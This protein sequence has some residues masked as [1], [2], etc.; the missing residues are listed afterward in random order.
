MRDELREILIANVHTVKGEVW[1]PSA[2]GPDLPKPHLVLREGNQNAGEAYASFATVYEVW[3]YVKRTTFQHV[4]ELSKEVISALNKKRFDVKGV[5]HYIEYI[6]TASEDIV[7]E[8]WD[9]LT[10][11]LRFQVYS[12]AWLV[13]STVKP[14]PVAAMQNWSAIKFTELQTDPA[15]WSPTDEKP[16]AYWRQVKINSTQPMNWGAWISAQLNCH[17]ISPDVSIRRVY[18]EKIVR[19]LA[20]DL[21]TYMSDNSLMRF[22]AVSAD[23]GLNPFLDGQVQLTVQF[24]ILKDK[25]PK[26]LLKN[27]YF[28][29]ERGGK[30]N[31]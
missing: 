8:E 12:L 19:Q 7:D 20:L 1:E 9:A 27:A 23:S 5:P 14:D 16:A 2:A 28:D 25:V 21:R 29:E 15:V 10:R 26:T 4:D 22:T 17:I 11:G 3:P 13:H 6:G 18:T 30:V 24:G 31:V